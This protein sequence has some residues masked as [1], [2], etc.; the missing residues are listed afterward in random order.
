MLKRLNYTKKGKTAF[1]LIELLVVI[2]IIAIL[3]GLL[4]PAVQK[5]RDAAARMTCSNNMKQMG[6]AS[7]NFLSTYSVFPHPGQLDSTGSSTTYYM[8]HSFGTQLLPY[9]EQEMVYKMFDHNSKV[10][11]GGT[12]TAAT[13]LAGYTAYSTSGGLHATAV[14]KDYDDSTHPSGWTAATTIINSF[15]CPSV[16]IAP[17]ARAGAD[18]LGSVD[19]MVPVVSDV[20]D[21]TLARG[22]STDKVMGMMGLNQGPTSCT[23]GLSNTIMVIEDAGRAYQAVANFGSGSSRPS[24]L[25]APTHVAAGNSS[26]SPFA[27]T[28]NARRVY[29]WADPDAFA[30]G[31]SG[32]SNSTGSKVAKINNSATPVGG[33]TE[34]KWSTN[35]CGPN[36]EPFSFH[37]GGVNATMG[38]GSVR[39]I[40]ETVNPI[41]LKYA[42]GATDGKIINLDE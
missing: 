23:D 41:T 42:I 30:N 21:T 35:N 31:F 25:T 16:P 19:Y 2:A 11:P 12:D 38:D 24:P 14:G 37:G 1:T 18:G 29:A 10:Y 32:P 34:C 5:V 15:I 27:A 22:G 36:D 4:L 26:S 8:V 33:P 9:I 20:S 28:T 17:L 40:R 7:H 13:P 39:F 6:L 3:I